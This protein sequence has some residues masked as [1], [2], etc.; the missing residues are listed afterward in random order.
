[1]QHKITPIPVFFRNA[2]KTFPNEVFIQKI[3]R[4]ELVTKTY[5]ES[6]EI[7]EK[8]TQYLLNSGIK[9]YDKVAIVASNSLEW[10]FTYLGVV[11]FGA[12]VVPVDRTL[13]IQ[14]IIHILKFSEVKS[15][16]GNIT[17]IKDILDYKDEIPQ[18]SL[19]VNLTLSEEY[20]GVI[21][22]EEIVESDFETIDYELPDL[23]NL[24][25]IIFTSG[26]TGLAKGVELTHRNF[27]SDILWTMGLIEIDETD[28]VYLILPMNH[29][30]AFTA[31]F[32]GAIYAGCSITCSRSYRPNEIL[33]DIK[34]TKVTFFLGVPLLFDKILTG[35]D[36]KIAEKGFITKAFVKTSLITSKIL[37]KT[38]NSDAGAKLFKSLREKTGLDSVRLFV[39]GGAPASVETVERYNLMGFKFIQGYGLTET[40]PVVTINSKTYY[41]I[42]SIGPAIP[43]I[44]V[45]IMNPNRN[46]VGEIWVKGDIVM[47]GYYNNKEATDKVITE[48]GWFKTGDLGLIDEE[49]YVFIK[50]RSKDVIVTSGGKNVY[51]EGI[52]FKLTR[53]SYI[54][55][56][57]VRGIPDQI[58]SGEN[59]EALIVPDYEYFE[60]HIS[61]NKAE[62][63]DEI[64][65]ESIRKEIYKVNE[66]LPAYKRIKDFQI[67][68]EEFEK[69]S[70]KKLKRYLYKWNPI[71]IGNFKN[72]KNK[73]P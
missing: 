25:S 56:A 1:M 66:K 17:N 9:K 49:G 34:N 19:Y 62:I 18:A 70:T 71:E 24:A 6:L 40:A 8:V 48:D 67:R 3:I 35:M 33:E 43:N 69:T 42:G 36:K 47:K 31:G 52:E 51:P 14:E 30:F 23:E 68:E 44:Q 64:I 50:G 60:E 39:S 13:P 21:N 38:F 16:F 32:L 2:V 37:K 72:K 55:E 58:S 5:R 29:V 63:T 15:V 11:S 73:K 46:D 54:L 59:I 12:I 20:E 41:K 26:T 45:K 61:R 28:C 10:A 53:S 27:C 7:V 65:R 57:I 4:E 22:F